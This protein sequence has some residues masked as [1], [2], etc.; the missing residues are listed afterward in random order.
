MKIEKQLSDD[1]ILREFGERLARVR[2]DRNWTQEQLAEQAGVSKRTVGRL[3][4]G[5]SMQLSSVIRIRRELDLLTRLDMLLPEP[6]PSPIEQ[7]IRRRK[8]RR[9][10]SSTKTNDNQSKNSWTWGD[11]P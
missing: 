1:T 7:L 11:K 3:E 10:A 8:M 4:S 5:E 2:V 6:I 9:R